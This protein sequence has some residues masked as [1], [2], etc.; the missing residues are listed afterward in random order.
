MKKS[1]VDVSGIF[2]TPCDVGSGCGEHGTK[3]GKVLMTKGI[4][5]WI[6]AVV[7][8]FGMS[9]VCCTANL[10]TFTLVSTRNIDWSRASEFTRSNQRVSG[11]DVRKII[12]IIPTKA[13]ITIQEAVDNA[14]QKVPG[15]VAM[16]DVVLKLQNYYIPYIYGRAAVYVEGSVLVD[17]KLASLHNGDS[18]RH[19]VFYTEDGKDFK[20]R[21]VSEAEYLTYVKRNIH[22]KSN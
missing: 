16:V 13:N 19:F 5:L 10:G 12:V 4:S 17:T 18:S 3:G 2:S 8:L 20:K 11:E 21:A 14:L 15:A 7:L 6:T 22:L 1:V 9:F